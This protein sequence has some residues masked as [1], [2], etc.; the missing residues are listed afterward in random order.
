MCQ[1]V[2]IGAILKQAGPAVRRRREWL[3]LAGVVWLLASGSI[4]AGNFYAGTTPATVPWTNG[5]V[6][7]EFT[8]TLTAAQT[9]TYLAGLREWELAGNVKFVSHTSQTHWI[10]FDYNTNFLNHVFP[11]TNPQVVTVSSLSRAQ[12]AHEMGHSFGFNHENIRVD[13]TNFLT[14]ISNNVTPGNLFYFQIDPTTVTNGPYDFESVM[15]LGWD[16]D[17]TNPGVAPTQ[18]PKPPY[19]PRYQF[20][21]GNYCLSPGDRAALAYLYG[22]PVVPLTNLVTTTADVGPGSLRAA[23]YYATDNPGTTVKFNIPVSD[24]G[25]SNGVFN[26]HLTGHLP[27]LVANG[28]VI[29]GST[30]RGFTNQPVIVVD[31]LQIIPETSTSDTVLVY[32]SSNQIKN[33]SFTGFDWNGLTLVY[34]DAT[35]NTI[36]GCWFGLGAGGTNAAPNAYQGILIANGAGG[37]VIGGTNALARNVLSGN[38][39]Y[40]VFITDSNTTG[41]VILGNYIGTGASGS[42]AVPNG[43]SGVF[44]G[45]GSSGNIIGGTNSGA[46]NILSG[47]LQYGL[48]ITGANTTNNTVLGN[49]IGPDA[50]GS[51]AVPNGESGVIIGGGAGGNTIGGTN[52]LVRNIL[53]G[54]LQYGIFMTNTVGNVIDGNYLGLN[55]SGQASLG[56]G[57]SGVGLYGGIQNIIGGT[58][59]GAG[60]VLSGNG[61]YGVEIGNPVATG[62]FVEGNI[63]GLGASG[64]NA[65]ANAL[66]GVLLAG[67]A[68]GNTIG[69]TVAGARNVISG[70]TTAGVFFTDVNTS[71]NLVA[72]NYVGTDI[73]GTN[74]VPN[75]LAGIYLPY[76]SPGNIIGGTIPGARNVISG[77]YYGV[78]LASPASAANV[79]EG[80]YLGVS[81]DGAHPVGSGFSGVIIFA[82]ANSNTIG[83]PVAG[84]GNVISGF[85]GYGIYISD[86]STAGNL[87]QGNILG[88]DVTGTNALGNSQGNVLVQAGAT[89]NVI[90]GT[91][92]GAGNVIAFA[93]GPGVKLLNADTTNNA[94]RGNSIFSN[95]ALGIDLNND[96]VTANH[97][98]FLAGPNDFQ[99]YPVITNV[100]GYAGST[101]VL[102]KFYSL[103]SRTYFIDV[104][105]GF[106]ADP[107]GYG[108]GRFYAGTVSVTTDGSGNANFSLT[109]SSGNY[110]GQYFTATA[111]SAGGDSSEFSFAFLATNAPVP[112][113]SFA[114][115]YLALANG[116]AFALNLQTNFSYRIQAATN[117]AQVPVAWADLT[118]FT[119]ANPVFNFTDRTATNYRVR[120]Y[121][122]A[123]P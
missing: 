16:F 94:I 122:V 45:N 43:L 104:Y 120:F 18:Q 42:N 105:R 117:L 58:V 41:N 39:Q 55:A 83:G 11:G 23:I 88:A 28:M 102:G 27:P 54:N 90:G 110:A 10:L 76:G 15:H 68:Q 29:D 40:G 57:L 13:Q 63:I 115:P 87:V 52:G 31:G 74:A 100:F 79:V 62:N 12:V 99:N 80:N 114:G 84:A 36:S 103:T 46:R 108:Q 65:I 47:N 8:N 60:N 89:G 59:A 19:F 35:N 48:L 37:N 1:E 118:N 9:N 71:N 53:S 17:S 67:G 26:I 101:I 73:T 95:G 97:T 3:F 50:S 56:N 81:P 107:S 98:G 119:A 111:T 66:G 75:T 86:A 5:I 106:T 21:L 72:G 33:L 14:V 112:S 6:P 7:Y 30:Q 69:G 70:N 64:T 22:P 32:S 93:G 51:N 123:S 85:W 25:Y 91:G 38:S 78:Y 44:I 82:G 24:A 4:S 96:G 2:M 61:N 121:R 34:A 116:F 113:A 109:N 20:R 49:Y 77:N 92:A